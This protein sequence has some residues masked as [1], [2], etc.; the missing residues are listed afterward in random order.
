M[1]LHTPRQGTIPWNDDHLCT[2]TDVG[3]GYRKD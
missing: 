1:H 2:D 3:E